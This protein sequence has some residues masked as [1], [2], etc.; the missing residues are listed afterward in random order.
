MYLF[1]G[2]IKNGK[3]SIR[4]EQS[5]K[6]KEPKIIH[7]QK[8][9]TLKPPMHPKRKW[10]SIFKERKK[11]EISRSSQNGLLPHTP[12]GRFI[13]YRVKKWGR[14]CRKCFT[15]INNFEI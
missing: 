5:T 10:F 2:Q 15:K 13:N 1:F 3:E 11:Y 7:P 4:E 8:F 14:S 9:K 12:D 6:V